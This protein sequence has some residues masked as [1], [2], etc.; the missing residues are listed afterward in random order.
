MLGDGLIMLTL[1]YDDD[2]NDGAG[3]RPA[4]RAATNATVAHPAFTI[5]E[6]SD[7]EQFSLDNHQLGISPTPS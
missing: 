7:R 1:Q 4:V 3:D 2:D 6:Q 5:V